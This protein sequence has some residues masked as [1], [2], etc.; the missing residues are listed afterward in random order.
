MMNVKVMTDERG[1]FEQ[2]G[3]SDTTTRCEGL[4]SAT[5]NSRIKTAALG[6]VK[7][8]N[9]LSDCRMDAHSGVQQ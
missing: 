6:D 2:R 8:D 3:L 4:T 7:F 1:S 9:L 5:G